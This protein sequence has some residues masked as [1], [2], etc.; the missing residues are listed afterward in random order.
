[1]SFDAFIAIDWSGAKGA[2]QRGIAVATAL[3][4][5]DYVILDRCGSGAWSRLELLE[6]LQNELRRYER[7]LVGFDFAFSFPYDE[8][9]GYLAGKCR[10][11]E[12]H[13]SLWKLVDSLS[14]SIDSRNFYGAGI[15]D[16]KTYSSL[17]FRGKRKTSNDWREINRQT[18]KA[19]PQQPSCIFRLVPYQRAVCKASLAGMRFLNALK[20]REGDRV[21]VW[22]FERSYAAHTVVE[23]FPTIFRDEQYGTRDKVEGRKLNFDVSIRHGEKRHRAN[24]KELGSDDTDALISAFGLKQLAKSG[25]QPKSVDH[26]V[27]SREGWIAGVPPFGIAT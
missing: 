24:S 16:H 5:A 11:V 8:A 3:P 9:L 27:I 13:L 12:N 23:I 14:E 1:V 19:C 4:S 20:A 22:P 26:R 6:W 7:A 10:D 2:R 21:A 15:I 25:W 17:F 18:E